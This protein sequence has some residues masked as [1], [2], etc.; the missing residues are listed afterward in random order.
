MSQDDID[1][2]VQ[3]LDQLIHYIQY[4]KN[5]QSGLICQDISCT[6]CK[7][8]TGED[9]ILGRI[10][11]WY[12][13]LHVKDGKYI[14]PVDVQ[15]IVP[16]IPKEEKKDRFEL[17]GEMIS[18]KSAP[19]GADLD[20]MERIMDNEYNELL[21]LSLKALKN[22][23]TV[24]RSVDLDGHTYC[25]AENCDFCKAQYIPKIYVPGHKMCILKLVND[26]ITQ[27]DLELHV[28]EIRKERE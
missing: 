23:D 27:H 12:K 7:L 14:T 4:Q 26:Y 10:Q 15:K 24:S 22:A 18:S 28:Q 3:V 2:V 1:Q 20:D 6:G 19:I 21:D 13:P 9:C 5:L 11:K 25:T 8:N 16:D 17:I